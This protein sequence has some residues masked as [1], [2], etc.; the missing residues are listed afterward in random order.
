MAAGGSELLEPASGPAA[1][2]M[3]FAEVA[4]IGG[5]RVQLLAL[6]RWGDHS[7]LRVGLGGPAGWL[8]RPGDPAVGRWTIAGANGA[9]AAGLNTGS[10]GSDLLVIADVV[11][12]PLDDIAP[13][14]TIVLARDGEQAEVVV[15]GSGLRQRSLVL[16]SVMDLPAADRRR[17]GCGRCGSPH[18]TASRSRCETCRRLWFELGAA[19]DANGW[20]ALGSGL[21]LVAELDP[22]PP[23]GM[24][25]VGIERWPG[26]FSLRYHAGPST[27]VWSTLLQDWSLADDRGHE[28]PGTPT[29]GSSGPTGHDVD[30]AFVGDL[31]PRATQLTV[32]VRD[33]GTVVLEVDLPL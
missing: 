29:G 5:V 28:H 12:P 8:T 18:V 17:N 7:Q 14:W 2:A 4:G 6:E 26:W 32:T 20:A 30:V 19:Q 13:P 33:H 9:S 11:L 16:P 22:G 23:G 25:F 27:E 21:P 24:S 1:V 3:P 10:R 15:D 31:D